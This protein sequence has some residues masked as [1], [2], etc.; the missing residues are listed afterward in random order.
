AGYIVY[1]KQSNDPN[2]TPIQLFISALI[3]FMLYFHNCYTVILTSFEGK[4]WC[5]LK[6]N[7]QLVPLKKQKKPANFAFVVPQILYI[8][9]TAFILF[10]TTTMIKARGGILNFS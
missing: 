4:K 7:L 10:I 9:N 8:V 6:G 5:Q 2:F 1:A 3:D